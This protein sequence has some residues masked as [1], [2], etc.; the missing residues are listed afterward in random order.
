MHGGGLE[1]GLHFLQK[2]FG[3]SN[4]AR[5]VRQILDNP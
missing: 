5:H 1:E 2:P 4:L 3:I